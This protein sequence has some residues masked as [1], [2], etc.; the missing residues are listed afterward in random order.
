M[1][2]LKIWKVLWFKKK[3][4]WISPR[5]PHIY[6][7]TGS[8]YF[9]LQWVLLFSTTKKKT[10]VEGHPQGI[11]GTDLAICENH[12]VWGEEKSSKNSREGNAWGT[13][14]IWVGQYEKKKKLLC[15]SG[16]ASLRFN[17]HHNRLLPQVFSRICHVNIYWC[18]LGI[19]GC[20][21]SQQMWRWS[22]GDPSKPDDFPAFKK[23]SV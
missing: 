17:S 13:F 20:W 7:I 3:S 6:L 11:A 22:S 12:T 8:F 18:V 1:S 15:F 21:F 19:K 10:V 23:M 9:S 2:V 16:C 4:Y 5:A 14:K